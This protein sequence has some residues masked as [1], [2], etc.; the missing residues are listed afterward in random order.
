[1]PSPFHRRT[2]VFLLLLTAF[3]PLSVPVFAQVS[4]RPEAQDRAAA[5]AALLSGRIR[6]YIDSLHIAG[7]EAIFTRGMGGNAPQDAIEKMNRVLDGTFRNPEAHRVS[8]AVQAWGRQIR[9]EFSDLGEPLITRIEVSKSAHT[10][11][12]YHGDT[13]LLETPIAV[14]NPEI[15]KETPDGSYH[16]LYVDF[17]PISRWRRGNVPYG[18]EYNP[19][20]SRQ[21][22]F[23]QDWTMHGNNDP[24]A[25]GKDISKGCVR[26]HNSEILVIAELVRAVQTRV[27]VHP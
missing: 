17:K 20:G 18:H 11:R 3:V 7:T 24:S 12:L 1:M 25:L 13:I 6:A 9:Q 22:P 23:Y 14:G 21:I 26:F 19:Y 5:R 16:V 4:P 10:A 27:E 8:A 15:G 2:A